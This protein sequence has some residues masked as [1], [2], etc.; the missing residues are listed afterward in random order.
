M[1]VFEPVQAAIT[2]SGTAWASAPRIR[3]TTRWQVWVRLLSAAG[4]SQLTIVAGV[5]TTQIG[6]YMPALGRM[7]GSTTILTA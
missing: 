1:L 7:S 5:A 6:R 3:S 4:A 2:R